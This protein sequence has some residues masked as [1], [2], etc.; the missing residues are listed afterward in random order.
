MIEKE[1][2]PFNSPDLNIPWRYH[3]WEAMHEVYLKASSAAKNSL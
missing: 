1:Q 3:V 2:W